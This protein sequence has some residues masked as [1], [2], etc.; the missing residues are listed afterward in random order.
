MRAPRELS[1]REVD[2]VGGIPPGNRRLLP[3]P[4]PRCARHRN[5][6]RRDRNLRDW[7]GGRSNRFGARHRAL[8]DRHQIGEPRKW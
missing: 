6:G 4:R 2:S 5:A 8:R 1:L 3:R 7:H